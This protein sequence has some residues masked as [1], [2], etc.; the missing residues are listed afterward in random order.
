VKSFMETIDE[1]PKRA[2]ANRENIFFNGLLAHVRQFEEWSG[3]RIAVG[4][5]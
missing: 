2:L 4:G 3:G 1:K 5:R